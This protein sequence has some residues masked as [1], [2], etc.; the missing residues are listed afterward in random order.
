MSKSVERERMPLWVVNLAGVILSFDVENVR[1]AVSTIAIP[2][3]WIPIDLTEQAKRDDI[4]DSPNF[5]AL[6]QRLQPNGKRMIRVLEDAEAASMMKGEAAEDERRRLNAVRYGNMFDASSPEEAEAEVA[7]MLTEEASTSDE[8]TLARLK[9]MDTERDMVNEVM[10][11]SSSES[12][13]GKVI[14][15]M[16]EYAEAESYGKLRKALKNIA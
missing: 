6:M 12:L 10:I 7:K 13:S 9:S 16:L 1:G 14:D 15:E 4:L 3:T 11:M 8:I 5:R 2:R